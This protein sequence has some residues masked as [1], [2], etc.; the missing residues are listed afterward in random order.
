MCLLPDMINCGLRMRGEWEHFSRHRLQRKPPVS[1]PSM[2]HGTCIM[3]IPRCMSGSLTRGG[4]ENVSGIPGAFYVSGKRPIVAIAYHRIFHG[5]DHM[6]FKR[7]ALNAC[8]HY[9]GAM[10]QWPSN[11]GDMRES[12][13]WCASQFEFTEKY[14]KF[15]LGGIWK[16]IFNND[17]IL[18]SD[19][20]Y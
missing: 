12:E 4:G 13:F 14:W 8:M 15:K 10:P 6:I 19:H 17:F 16:P 2:H 9:P 7:V 20:M 11:Q 1:D 18:I 3:H 5:A